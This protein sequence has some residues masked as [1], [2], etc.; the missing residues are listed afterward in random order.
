MMQVQRTDNGHASGY[1]GGVNERPRRTYQRRARGKELSSSALV[2]YDPSQAQDSRKKNG[3]SDR[4]SST[5][6]GERKPDIS[7][8]L[9]VYDPRQ[10]WRG[11]TPRQASV[12]ETYKV[13][14]TVIGTGSFG[15]VRSCIHRQSGKKLAIKSIKA[16]AE[17]AGLLTNEITLLSRVNHRHIVKVVDILKDKGY[18]HIV[19]EQCTGG[20][21]F[22]AAVGGRTRLSERR[23]RRIIRDLLDAI[24][25]LHE[26]NIVHRD[27]KVCMW[28]PFWTWIDDRL[29]FQFAYSHVHV[30]SALKCKTSRLNI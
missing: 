5:K 13:L 2:I 18:V 6:R 4:R 10:S 9:V 1:D 17:N 7:Q 12:R 14:P 29:L 28:I 23:V 22:D 21:L 27:L 25:Y 24:A 19:M 8:Q 16:K 15:T 30:S 3:R 26:R 11:L 20:D